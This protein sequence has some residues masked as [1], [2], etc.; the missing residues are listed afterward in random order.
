MDII[1]VT[2]R[3]TLADGTTAAKGNVTFELTAPLEDADGNVVATTGEIKVPLLNGALSQPLVATNSPGLQ[4]SGVTY[5]V[6]ERLAP[7]WQRTYNVGI[8]YDAI[9]GT[10]DLADL[11]PVVDQDITYGVTLADFDAH[12]ALTSGVHGI[13]NTADLETQA[14]AQ[15][16]ATAAQ[17]AA[18]T[19]ATTKA[20]AAE[21]AAATDAQARV[22]THNAATFDIHGLS[23]IQILTRAPYILI[24]AAD[25]PTDVRE[26]ADEVLDGVAD[27]AEINGALAERAV[28]LSSGTFNTA[29]KIAPPSNRSLSGVGMGQTIINAA[30]TANAIVFDSFRENVTIRD[31][32]VKSTITSGVGSFGG[33]SLRQ[34]SRIQILNV[35]IHDTNDDA[36]AIGPEV[37][38][39][40]VMGCRM[41][42]IGN[43]N[44]INAQAG[45]EY[46]G[47]SS[48]GTAS[49]TDIQLISNR[50]E[51]TVGSGIAL[52]SNGG[53]DLVRVTVMGN[54]IFNTEE[55]NMQIT[56]TPH[57]V[58]YGT[59]VG[60]VLMNGM[61]QA[62]FRMQSGF[63]CTVMG[64]I[65]A[66]G[67]SG[68]GI[69]I[70]GDGTRLQNTKFLGNTVYAV[71]GYGVKTTGSANNLWIADT[72][73]TSAT[74]GAISDGMTGGVKWTGLHSQG[75]SENSGTA[76]VGAAATSVAV[77]HGLAKAP[78]LANI[79]VTP[80]SSLGAGARFWISTPTATQFTVNV[81]VAPGGSGATFAWRASLA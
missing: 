25:A 76:T 36:V 1:I 57:G 37:S 41:H 39:L 16:K 62:R 22:D 50:I 51:G 18:A 11:A 3:F 42:T 47:N 31:L 14:G 73:I 8:P 72:T 44:P 13:T 78:T 52:S 70:E 66:G 69:L 32:T 79:Q 75:K 26:L 43:R 15:A 58:A 34:S 12:K 33:I 35:E 77:N 20:N 53:F 46:Y 17:T 71:P 48:L 56:G 28:R 65:M 80:T 23:S 61:G 64:N 2:R 59:I 6:T 21:A 27:D 24:A 9:N 81:D 5:K 54:L 38:K 4:P 67:S 68:D 30:P 7:N 49:S 40:L 45:I 74:A 29:L 60:N 19:D 63:L 10:V 55:Y